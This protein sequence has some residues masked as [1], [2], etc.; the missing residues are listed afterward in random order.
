MLY[1]I[2]HHSQVRAYKSF[3]VKQAFRFYG[4]K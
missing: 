2:S 3:A 1:I 4:D